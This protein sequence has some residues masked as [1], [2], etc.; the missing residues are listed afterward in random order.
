MRKPSTRVWQIHSFL[1]T[2][3]I[4]NNVIFGSSLVAMFPQL[5]VPFGKVVNDLHLE[6]LRAI[7]IRDALFISA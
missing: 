2:A 6:L 4:I 3:P 7:Y 5:L 1:P